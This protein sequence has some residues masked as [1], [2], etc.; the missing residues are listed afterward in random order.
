MR[1]YVK[2]ILY[3]GFKVS[4]RFALP[5]PLSSISAMFSCSNCRDPNE[6]V[7][8]GMSDPPTTWQA[9]SALAAELSIPTRLMNVID[10]QDYLLKF[11]P[12]GFSLVAIDM[13]THQGCVSHR[14]HMVKNKEFDLPRLSFRL[15]DS[16]PFWRRFWEKSFPVTFVIRDVRLV[17]VTG[18]ADR[19][20]E[21]PMRHEVE[22]SIVEYETHRHDAH[23]ARISEWCP[24]GVTV[25]DEPIPCVG[26]PLSSDEEEQG[27]PEDDVTEA[28]IQE[29][30]DRWSKQ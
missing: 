16:V 24:N 20:V 19:S 21:S 18:L 2:K 17:Y 25:S 29:A 7:N 28:D 3:T 12:V 26:L 5:R 4:L 8:A 15:Y 22:Y 30:N 14:A 27:R 1:R 13:V 9:D 6:L 11:I 10:H 23:R